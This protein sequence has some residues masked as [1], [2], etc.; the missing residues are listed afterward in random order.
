MDRPITW[1]PASARSAAATDESTPPDI[2]TTTLI[3]FRPMALGFGPLTRAH[4]RETSQLR[5]NSRQNGDDV[6]DLFLRITRAEAEAN[7]VLRAMARQVHGLQH[8]RRLERARR[9]RRSGRYRDAFEV[10]RNQQ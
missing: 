5:H 6:I 3:G 2:A 1:W 9:A 7:R 10:E 8:V 4:C